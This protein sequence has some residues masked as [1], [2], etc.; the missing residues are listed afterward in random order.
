MRAYSSPKKDLQGLGGEAKSVSARR[1]AGGEQS[2]MHEYEAL[3]HVIGS[4][5]SPRKNSPSF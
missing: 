3:Q 5:D 1:C 4:D 2:S